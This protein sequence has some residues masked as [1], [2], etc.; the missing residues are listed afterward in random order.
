MGNAYPVET[1]VAVSEEVENEVLEVCEEQIY[2]SVNHISSERRVP[3][4][5]Q[6]TV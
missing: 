4:H 6:K 5:L 2:Q 3:D 1:V